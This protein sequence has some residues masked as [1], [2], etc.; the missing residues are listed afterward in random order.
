MSQKPIE[1]EQDKIEYEIEQPHSETGL[2]DD[3]SNGL[4]QSGIF[5]VNKALYEDQV[6]TNSSANKGFISVVVP[7]DVASEQTKSAQ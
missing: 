4:R 3:D 2:A 7:V 1:L 5:G 6:T